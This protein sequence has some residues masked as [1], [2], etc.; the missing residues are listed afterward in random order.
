MTHNEATNGMGINVPPSTKQ[1]VIYFGQQNRSDK[2]ALDFYNYYKGLSWRNPRG[3]LIR[4]WKQ[5]AW[6]WIWNRKKREII[7]GRSRK[8]R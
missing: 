2:N 8:G 4:N 5:L 1:V 3:Q 6:Q 7:F